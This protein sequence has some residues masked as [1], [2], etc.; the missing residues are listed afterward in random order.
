[1]TRVVSLAAR[2]ALE[3]ASS[4]P[5]SSTLCALRAQAQPKVS[6]VEKDA[7]DTIFGGGARPGGSIQV[8]EVIHG[9]AESLSTDS[10]EG[11]VAPLRDL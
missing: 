10:A 3:H 1:M 9:R 4:P 7:G 11:T 2:G 5:L 6:P 8:V